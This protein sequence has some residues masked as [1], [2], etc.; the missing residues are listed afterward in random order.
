M[1]F[2]ARLFGRLRPVVPAPV[3]PSLQKPSAPPAPATLLTLYDAYGRQVQ[4]PREQW[5]TEIL[6]DALRRV[7]LQPDALAGIIHQSLE[8]G[9][10][11]DVL[12][13]A[14]HLLQIDPHPQ[15]AACLLGVVYLQLARPAEA[16]GVFTEYIARHGETGSIL[17]NLAKVYFAQE[18]AESLIASTL[19]RG[20][21]LDPN[22][23]NGLG[24]FLALR[25]NRGGP[26][27]VTA[28]LER[29]AALPG[30]W[31]AQCSL[32][33]EALERR[34]LDAALRLFHEVL[35]RTPR[36]VPVDI[37]QA[38]S[39]D[40]GKH[41]HL[42]ELLAI[43]L[44]HFD[45]AHHGLAVG[46]NLIKA[47]LDL[48]RLEAARELL[49][50]LYA[51][52][53]IDWSQPLAYWEEEIARARLSIMS[54]PQEQPP[55]ALLALTGPIW[56]RP[57]SPAAELF[58]A[59]AGEAPVIAVY[60]ASVEYPLGAARAQ[61]QLSDHAGRISRALPL[62]LA[63]QAH[64]RTEASACVLQSWI[65]SLQ[66]A[67]AVS[68]APWSDADAS[69]QVRAQVP[70]ADYVLLPH[71]RA[72]AEPWAVELR[73]I[74]TIDA[75]LLGS[76]SLALS[77]RSLGAFF[78]QAGEAALALLREHAELPTVPAPAG[79]AVPLAP[80]VGEYALRLEQALAVAV[81]AMP[82]AGGGSLNREREIVSGLLQ[83]SLAA[84]RNLPARLLL[85]QALTQLGKVRAPVVAEFSEKVALLQR[86]H[87]LPMPAHGVLQRMIAAL[88]P[89]SP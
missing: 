33:R 9:F 25:R 70:P 18:K 10:I 5:R 77:P 42:P 23:E 61:V 14:R 4:M 39:G 2:F 24:W 82:A 43:T 38:I 27:A 28:A 67:F 11:A 50:R 8:D 89:A 86:E 88:F 13:P 62:F 34:D 12:E 87:P 71:I 84:P 65:P 41:G 83:L 52:K 58:P 80:D 44:P 69:A 57:S 1:G 81:A 31:R 54:P 45:V 56:L 76:C 3:A 22:Q 35:S 74:R 19:W 32:A 85:V 17:T 59:K 55:I 46:S 47:H 64:F 51:L 79:Y 20:L 40:L 72:T 7:W 29:V 78:T 6:P 37:L 15:R 73:L 63:E 30:S 53:R 68:S 26:A 49:D 48:G 66:G 75:R 36:P 21:T 16:E 60:C